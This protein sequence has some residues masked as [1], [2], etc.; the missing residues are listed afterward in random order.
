MYWIEINNDCDALNTCICVCAQDP[1]VHV[2]PF[3]VRADKTAMDERGQFC[4]FV[5]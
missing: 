4:N 3:N 2:L 1:T 5:Y